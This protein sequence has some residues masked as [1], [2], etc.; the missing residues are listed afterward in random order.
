MQSWMKEAPYSYCIRSMSTPTISN[1]I[2][3]FVRIHPKQIFKTFYNNKT[4]FPIIEP[5]MNV[6]CVNVN[7]GRHI[8]QSPNF[9]LC[10]MSHFFFFCVDMTIVL[11]DSYLCFLVKTNYNT[12]WR[13]CESKPV[14]EKFFLANSGSLL[15]SHEVF[16]LYFISSCFI[17]L[18]T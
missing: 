15:Y 18:P 2:D 7:G 6:S 4:V 5:I 14:Y 3:L 9:L 13:G 1:N 16:F 11:F 12:V 10:W 17:I 8:Q